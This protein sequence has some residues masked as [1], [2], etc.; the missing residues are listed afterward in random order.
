MTS[1]II[2]P[3]V[4]ALFGTLVG[5]LAP[6]VTSRLQLR[7]KRRIEKTRW[8]LDA[9]MHEHKTV[10]ELIID[11]KRDDQET[12]APLGAYI[13]YFTRLHDLIDHET[14]D[15]ESLDDLHRQHKS[16]VDFYREYDDRV[17]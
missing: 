1:E 2:I 4:A 6:I 13:S 5:S 12:I 15:Q 7:E 10:H 14:F 3:V 11:G 16:I 17:E 9:A 8:V